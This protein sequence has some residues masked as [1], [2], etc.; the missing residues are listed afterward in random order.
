MRAIEVRSKIAAVRGLHP[1]SKAELIIQIEKERGILAD[2]GRSVEGIRSDDAGHR[3]PRLVKVGGCIVIPGEDSD[4]SGQNEGTY[5]AARKPRIPGVVASD[6]QSNCKKYPWQKDEDALDVVD[7]SQ[8]HGQ[9]CAGDIEQPAARVTAP[10][11][12]RQ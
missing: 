2:Y 10:D 4:P 11:R 5:R 3:A 12:D 7:A 1:R 6:R 9:H 8:F